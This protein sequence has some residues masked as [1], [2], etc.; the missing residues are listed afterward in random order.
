MT[1]DAGGFVLPSHFFDRLAGTVEAPLRF[2][3]R[4]APLPADVRVIWRLPLLLLTLS[5]ARGRRV[6]WKQLHLLSSGV[7]TQRGRARFVRALEDEQAPD[8]PVV[9]FEPALEAAVALAVGLGFARWVQ[10]RRLEITAHG[11]QVVAAVR[12]AGAFAMEAQ[13]LEHVGPRLSMARSDEI[14][15]R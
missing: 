3:S 11:E 10:G 2:E 9:R 8:E 6:S 4:P 1:D 12:E 15:D 5:L 7:R 13:F 14:L